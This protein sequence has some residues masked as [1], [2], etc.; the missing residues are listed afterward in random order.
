MRDLSKDR[1]DILMEKSLIRGHFA[2]NLSLYVNL[3]GKKFDLF[4]LGLFSL[5]DIFLNKPLPE[6]IGNL[7]LSSEVKDALLKRKGKFG[8]VLNLIIAHE[9]GDWLKVNH[10]ID[11]LGIKEDKY[12]QCYCS[13]LKSTQKAL[14]AL[15]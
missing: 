6:I 1:P 3:K 2:E 8:I 9:K 4:V 7:S 12:M 14:Q 11:E 15:S 13:A 10:Y 5:I